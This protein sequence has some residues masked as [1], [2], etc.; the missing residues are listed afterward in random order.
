MLQFSQLLE[1]EGGVV[2]VVVVYGGGALSEWG[3]VAWAW[4]FRDF[5]LG[6]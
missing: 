1:V 3:W 6:L 5:L 2:V 4:I